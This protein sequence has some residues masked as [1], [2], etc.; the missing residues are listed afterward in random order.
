[1]ISYELCG[2]EP[3]ADLCSCSSHQYQLLSFAVRYNPAKVQRE[4]GELLVLWDD[5]GYDDA[6]G[7]SML[8][9]A[10]CKRVWRLD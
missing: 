4:T 3:P 9:C 7:A 2:F 6:D 1:M 10:A 8:R 5:D